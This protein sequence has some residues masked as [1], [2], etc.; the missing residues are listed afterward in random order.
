M[1]LAS[2]G[3]VLGRLGLLAGQVDT[4]L[5]TKEARQ[6]KIERDAQAARMKF[7][8][9]QRQFNL[10]LTK[11][12]DVARFNQMNA[13]QRNQM[14][15]IGTL[16]AAMIRANASA[17]AA[18][19]PDSLDLGNMSALNSMINSSVLNAQGPDG[20]PLF[21]NDAFDGA[22]LKD[23]YQGPFAQ[24][25]GMVRDQILSGQIGNDPAS[26]NSA[27][28]D[29]LGIL[30]PT[31]TTSGMGIMDG[32]PSA[33]MS[34][35][36]EMGRIISAFKNKLMTMPQSERA[37]EVERFRQSLLSRQISPNVV[38]QIVRMAQSGI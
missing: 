1:A 19:V 37:A 30:S 35:G 5:D 3:N 2:F 36:G 25:T 11:D 16:G 20:Q 4:A 29:A 8:E 38:A 7:V 22:D 14:S 26:I 15:T 23:I 32:D 31:V 6:A 24:I 28:N 33:S 13:N 9:D 27:I 12:Y 10:G 17:A 18:G 34:F 21:G